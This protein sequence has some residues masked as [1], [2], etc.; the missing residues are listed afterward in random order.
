MKKKSIASYALLGAAGAA[1]VATA[2]KAAKFVPEKRELPPLNEEKVD[3]GRC[4][5]HLSKAISIP[6]KKALHIYSLQKK[7]KKTIVPHINTHK[8]LSKKKDFCFKK[9]PPKYKL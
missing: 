7:V 2:I 4:L 6:C 1:A 5:E 3:A 8:I 9:T